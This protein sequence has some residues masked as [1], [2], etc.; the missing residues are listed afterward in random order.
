MNTISDEPPAFKES[1]HRVYRGPE[2]MPCYCTRAIDHAAGPEKI[3][4]VGHDCSRCAERDRKMSLLLEVEKVLRQIAARKRRTAEQR[5][6]SSCLVFVD[7][8]SNSA[9]AQRTEEAQP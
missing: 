1:T 6:A 5:L 9:A 8:L 4:C 7:A 2:S 3:G